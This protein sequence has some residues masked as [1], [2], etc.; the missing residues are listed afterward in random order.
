MVEPAVGQWP[1]EAFVEEQ[2]QERH[3]H[4]FGGEVVGIAGAVAL[5]EPMPFQLAEIVAELVQPVGFLR[6]PKRGEDGF[7][8]LLGSPAA[9]GGAAVQQN[10]HQ[11][12]NPRFMDLDSGIT[13]GA[14]GHR[15]CQSLQQREIHMDVEPLGLAIGET[16]GNDLESFAHGIEMLEPL[17]QTEVAQIIGAKFVAQEA[18][19]LFIL[20]EEGVFP[21]GSEDMMTVLDLLDDRRQFAAQPLVEPDAEDLADAIGRQ[22]P[23]PEFA[24]ALEDLVD[25]KVALEDEV[26]AVLD[27]R[28]GV[29]PNKN[30]Q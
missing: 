22:T 7:V 19:E 13:D 17:L 15:Q 16:I 3:L 26:A 2:E 9:D 14:N 28:D 4:T 11:A 21:V 27:L 24:A 10:F 18:G 8:D 29:K 6:E 30:V 12:N 23:E 5:Q 25:G 1:A 20:L